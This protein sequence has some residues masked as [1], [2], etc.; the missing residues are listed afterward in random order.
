MG[1]LIEEG[2]EILWDAG[3][4]RVILGDPL[5]SWGIIGDPGRSL[6]ILGGPGGYCPT[7]KWCRFFYPHWLRESVSAV[8]RIIFVLQQD[9]IN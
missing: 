5:E 2:T 3:G 7:K 9:Q 6:K 4:S 1:D 8:S